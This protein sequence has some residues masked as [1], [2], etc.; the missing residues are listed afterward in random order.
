MK[1]SFLLLLVTI[2]C[3]SLVSQNIRKPVVQIAPNDN[4]DRN[5]TN[6]FYITQIDTNYFKDL[7]VKDSKIAVQ[8][9]QPWCGGEKD[10]IPNVNKL[11]EKLDGLGLPFIMISDHPGELD[12]FK[13]QPRVGL[14]AYYFNKYNIS[15][16]T[17][18]IG[19][20]ETLDTYKHILSRYVSNK[21]NSKHFC[22]V[23]E[24]GKCKYQNFT[25]YFYRKYLK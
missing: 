25:Y 14:I 5:D 10:L 1:K 12:Y 8:F 3:S 23:V 17:Y 2:I 6:N 24:D 20:D 4:Y 18:I 16:P 22:F 7:L 21:V 19:K 13:L 11:K 15:F 9:W